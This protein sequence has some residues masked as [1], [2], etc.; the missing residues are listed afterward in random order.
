MTC[1]LY[2]NPEVVT[3]FNSIIELFGGKPMTIE[4]FKDVELRNKRTGKDLS[5]MNIAYNAW[6]KYEGNIPN[7]E[8]NE[9]NRK[10]EIADFVTNKINQL[11]ANGEIDRKC[12]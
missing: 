8:N 5:A 10:K 7:L 12:S 1:P 11:I 4:E 3:K 6:D 2:T 9:A